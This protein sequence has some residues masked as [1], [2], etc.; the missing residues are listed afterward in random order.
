[1]RQVVEWQEQD[2]EVPS[3]TELYEAGLDLDLDEEETDP[4]VVVEEVEGS[5]GW[6]EA[7]VKLGG[8]RGWSTPSVLPATGG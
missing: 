1:M 6:L 2:Q 4:G 5:V 8:A 7:G 3:C